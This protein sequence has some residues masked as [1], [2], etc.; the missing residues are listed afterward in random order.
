[1]KLSFEN[2]GPLKKG[3]I[4]LGDLTVVTGP[5]NTG[6]TYLTYLLYGILSRLTNNTTIANNLHELLIFNTPKT[7]ESDEFLELSLSY[8]QIE[9]VLTTIEFP[10]LDTYLAEIFGT[11]K[12]R[13]LKY[14]V[15]NIIPSFFRIKNFVKSNKIYSSVNID[16]DEGKNDFINFR[17]KK[18]ELTKVLEEINL[19]SENAES[20]FP[21][22]LRNNLAVQ[23]LNNKENVYTYILTST[24][25]GLI[26]FKNEI[27]NSRSDLL[28]RIKLDLVDIDEF[29][30]KNLGLPMAIQDSLKQLRTNFNQFNLP[31]GPE[32]DL[33]I[34][35]L[36][37]KFS[38]S[39]SNEVLFTP[40]N[41]STT[42]NMTEVSSTVKS[43][44]HV[45]TF[46]TLRN[47]N[48]TNTILF[49]DEPELNLH[50]ENQIKLA[51]LLAMLVNMGLKVFLT[52]HSDYII[53][54]FNNLI[55]LKN[56]QSEQAK[57]LMAKEGIN[58]NHVLNAEQVKAYITS[59]EKEGHATISP[60]NIDQQFGMERTA[61]DRTIEKQMNIYNFLTF[62]E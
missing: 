15:K 18:A 30:N 40:N 49:I 54:E 42:F 12:L 8:E 62:S 48:Y 39:S 14:S 22:I 35:I 38:Y 46:L 33:L 36:N 41:T 17:V 27:D 37:G 47:G 9:K 16:I 7:L 34:D 53:R 3:E 2:L 60:V 5:N 28:N 25:E 58:S 1:M 57:D 23:L 45:F 55:M 31:K 4:T 44:A 50:P 51:R 32:T 6:K 19:T 59:L 43:M 20:Y 26:L 56:A 13:E 61:F 29:R 52:T 24:R 11:N 21:I 10:F